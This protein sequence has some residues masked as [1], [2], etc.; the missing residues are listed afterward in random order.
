MLTIKNAQLVDANGSYQADIQL[1]DGKI[2]AIG[3]DLTGGEEINA[4]GLV[5]MPAFVEPHAHFRDPGFPQKEDLESGSRSALQGGYGTVHL[6]ANT[7]PTVDNP[8]TYHYIMNKAN[9]LGLINILQTYAVTKGLEGEEFVDLETLPESVTTLSEDGH[10]LFNNKA[11]YELFERVKEKDLLLMIHEEDK[12]LSEIDYRL[13]EDVHT[14]RD[15]YF[16]GKTGA[17]I[18]FCHVSTVDALEAIAHGKEKGYPVTME[19]APHHIYLKD[20]DYKVHPPIRAQEDV[21]A[22]VQGILDGT[23]DCIA[24]DHAPHTA[25]D[26]EKGSPGLIGLETAFGVTYHVLVEQYGQDLS[27]VSQLMSQRPA[28]ILNLNKG[29]LQVGYDADLVLVDLNESTTY[30]T[31][32]SRSNNTP[33]INQTFPTKIMKTIVNGQVKFER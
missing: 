27:L 5:C 21:N 26:K 1:K 20:L 3:Q 29:L 22:L 15:V 16:S 30:D 23:V 33:F 9:E 17:R 28:E 18:H 13:A 2:F 14:M 4:K 7:K 8:E 6:M 12:E 32:A 10:G 25:E 19:V 24:T 31:F 11:T